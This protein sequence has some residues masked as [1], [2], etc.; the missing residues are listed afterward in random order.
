MVLLVV[1]Y[2]L[3]IILDYNLLFGTSVVTMHNVVTH[4]IILTTS[5]FKF[6]NKFAN[7]RDLMLPM[8]LHGTHFLQIIHFHV[9]KVISYTPPAAI[10]KLIAR[11]NLLIVVFEKLITMFD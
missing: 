8:A 4:S 5:S 3:D 11:F 6:G 7:F 2:L 9:D 1:N 10:V